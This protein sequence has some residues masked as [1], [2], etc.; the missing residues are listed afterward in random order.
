MNLYHVTIED[1]DG[2]DVVQDSHTFHIAA[3]NIGDAIELA[4]DRAEEYFA[5]YDGSEDGVWFCTDA[6]IV[7]ED[8]E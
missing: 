3:E 7:E 6:E 5:D 4:Y 1:R 8:F 2:D